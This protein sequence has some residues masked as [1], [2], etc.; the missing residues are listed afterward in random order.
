MF[1]NRMISILIRGSFVWILIIAVETVHGIARTV[2]LEPAI[3]DLR[4]KQ[5]S[6][7][8]GS[9]LILAIAFI[10]VRWLKGSYVSEFV[11]VGIMWV[12]LTIGFEI[13]LGRLVIG[14]SWDRIG[15]D[16]DLASGG[17]MPLGLLVMLFAPLAMAKIVDEV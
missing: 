3:G 11:A 5:V 14:L 9:S 6:V 13:L 16:Y 17:L 7:F 10:F 4:A 1:K 12:G 15:S 2:F 8:I